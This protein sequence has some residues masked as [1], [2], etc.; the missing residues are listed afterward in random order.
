MGAFV[1]GFISV[2]LMILYLAVLI[3]LIWMFG[4]FVHAVETIAKKIEG[5]SKI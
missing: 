5:S 3:Y 1:G 4:R 2:V